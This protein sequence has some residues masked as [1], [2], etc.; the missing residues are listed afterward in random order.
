VLKVIG[1]PLFEPFDAVYLLD[2]DSY[3][4]HRPIGFDKAFPF[5]QLVPI[6]EQEAWFNENSKDRNRT[7]LD[8]KRKGLNPADFKRGSAI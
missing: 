8:L 3:D 6:F 1:T 2:W 4:K 7:Y 5:L